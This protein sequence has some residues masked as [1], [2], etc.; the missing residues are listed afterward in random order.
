MLSVP[1]KESLSSA[2]D[3]KT[4]TFIMKLNEG[5]NFEISFEV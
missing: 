4:K 3:E 5:T 1:Y 2:A